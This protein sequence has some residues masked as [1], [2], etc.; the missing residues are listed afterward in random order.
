M[1]LCGNFYIY[2]NIDFEKFAYRGLIC[3]LCGHEKNNKKDINI[4]KDEN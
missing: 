2:I 1:Q 3:N 4:F